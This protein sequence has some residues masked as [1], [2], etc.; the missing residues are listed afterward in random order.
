MPPL[1]SADS[2]LRIRRHQPTRLEGFVDASFAFAVTL[3]VISV[4]HVPASV[5]DMLQALRGMPAFGLSFLLLVRIWNAHRQWSRH[6]DI[7]DGTTTGLSL[8]LVFIVLVFVYPLRFLFAL[9]VSWLSAGFLAEQ[10]ILIQTIDEF[11]MA[12]VVYGLAFVA[13]ALIFVRLH[14]HAL[15]RAVDLSAREAVATRMHASLWWM[16]GGIALLSTLAAALLPFSTSKGW[17]FAVPGTLY[18]L[19]GIGAP[20]IRRAYARDA[21]ALPAT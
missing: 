15:R 21:A 8:A 9:L 3:L 6:Y 13:I 14:V 12:F 7:E 5:P 20:A 1:P 18:A 10:P 19:I 4:G 16:Q 11:R 17:L 2:A